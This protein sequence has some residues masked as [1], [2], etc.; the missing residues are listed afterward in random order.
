VKPS[1]PV[2]LLVGATQQFTATGTYSDGSTANVT[3]HVTWKSSNTNIAVSGIGV[4]SATGTGTADITATVNG[5]TSQAISLTVITL[6]SIAVTPSTPANLIVG[7]TQQFTATGTY[8]DGSTA[9]L[10][11]RVTWASDT[12]TT[13]TINSAGLTTGVT[14]GTTNITATLDG[15]TSANLT[16]IVISVTSIAVTPNPPA[17]LI[18]GSS[19]QFV[20]TG[21]Y[22]NGAT[23]DISSQVTWSSGT[24][25]VATISSIGLATGISTGIANITATWNGKASPSVAL[26]VTPAASTGTST[27]TSTTAAP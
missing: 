10:S 15:V 4:A 26:T 21:T 8:S 9:D 27:T 14:A 20:A 5:I 6:S 1:S 22:S 19:E 13:A 11:S 23:A 24:L 16:L 2:S 12:S 25:S 3:D 18:A 17:N 7:S